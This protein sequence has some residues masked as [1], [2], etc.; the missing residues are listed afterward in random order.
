M[1]VSRAD[2]IINQNDIDKAISEAHNKLDLVKLKAWGYL[3]FHFADSH[4]AILS[5]AFLNYVLN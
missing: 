3:K 5:L 1:V 2:G 4:L